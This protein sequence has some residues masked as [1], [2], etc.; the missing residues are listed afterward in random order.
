[1]GTELALS[2][3]EFSLGVGEGKLTSI[4][5]SLRAVAEVTTYWMSFRLNV[6]LGLAIPSIPSYIQIKKPSQGKVYF[7][8]V[9]IT[10]G[11]FILQILIAYV[12]IDFFGLLIES[13]PGVRRS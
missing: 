4:S 1:M 11:I 9:L 8:D 13:P 7:Q 6:N 2:Q 10:P 5:A 3:A 12:F